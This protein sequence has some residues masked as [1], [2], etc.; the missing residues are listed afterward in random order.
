MAGRVRL[1]PV[2]F[3]FDSYK[4]VFKYQS[5]WSGYKILSYIP[6]SER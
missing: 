6:L 1:L 2:E 4:A 5:I 3:T